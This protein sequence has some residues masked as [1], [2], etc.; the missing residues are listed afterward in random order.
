[1]QVSSEFVVSNKG[2]ILLKHMGY[3]HFLHASS[4]AAQERRR[5][6]CSSQKRNCRVMVT[7]VFNEIVSVRNQHNHPPTHWRYTCKPCSQFS[8]STSCFGKPVLVCGPYRFNKHCYYKGS[9]ARCIIQ[10]TT[11]ANEVL[12]E[13]NLDPVFIR[14]VFGN[15]MIQIGN[16]KFNLK[17]D[18]SRK[19]GP[20]KR[21]SSTGCR[22]TIITIDNEI[23][24]CKN[25]HNH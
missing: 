2:G 22:A 4:G 15:P 16:Y 3:T 8:L 9:N 21:W 6:R 5:W 18:N 10:Y 20:K 24:S 25:E 7:T 12:F 23:I 19:G 17:T 13:Y 14:S 11:C 1:M